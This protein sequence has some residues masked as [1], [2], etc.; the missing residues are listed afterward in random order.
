[1]W[2]FG[3]R[4]MGGCLSDC[5]QRFLAVSAGLNFV[6]NSVMQKVVL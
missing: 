3:G 5:G 6:C 2:R 1:M 4:E